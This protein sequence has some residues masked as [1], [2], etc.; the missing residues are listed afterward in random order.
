MSNDSSLLKTCRKQDIAKG[1]WKLLK[2]AVLERHANVQSPSSIHCFRGF[3]LIV[4]RPCNEVKEIDLPKLIN[5]LSYIKCSS[6]DWTPKLLLHALHVNV[7]ALAAI[8][9]TCIASRLAA[10]ITIEV[11]PPLAEPVIRFL[12]NE[13]HRAWPDEMEIDQLSLLSPKLVSVRLRTGTSFLANMYAL[14][15]REMPIAIT[16]EKIH[17]T[18]SLS[19]LVS[20][21]YNNGVGNTGNVCVWDAEKVLAWVVLH[22]SVPDLDTVVEIGVGMAGLAGLALAASGP[23]TLH[24]YLT[25]GNDSCVLNNEVNVLLMNAAQ[26]LTPG[27][28]KVLCRQLTWS[29]ESGNSGEVF[30]L[31]PAD[32]T[33]ASDCTHFEE[34]HAKLLWTLITCTK[35]HGIIW[36]CQPARGKSLSRFLDMVDDINERLP[37]VLRVSEQVY[38]AIE[39]SHH[40][41]RATSGTYYADVHK[42][43]VFTMKKVREVSEIDRQ[44]IR[45][46]DKPMIA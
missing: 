33:L 9:S 27:G 40:S 24:V 34:H 42:P 8:H 44:V 23:S 20:H 14:L 30:P 7:L 2:Q 6:K 13:K 17:R 22:E 3:G 35:V 4:S 39:R 29:C 15:N 38:N 32:W 21:Q 11:S 31:P 10:T 37:Q 43:L 41:F 26:V 45:Q 16:R 46:Y 1:R 28:P 18:L 12:H 19:D 5:S 25:D 36:I